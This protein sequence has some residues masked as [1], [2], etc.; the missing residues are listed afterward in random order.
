MTKKIEI[1]FISGLNYPLRKR[2]P[3]VCRTPS[4]TEQDAGYS[5]KEIMEKYARG[6]M[7]VKSIQGQYVDEEPDFDDIDREKFLS[8]DLVERQELV[9]SVK[10]KVDSLTKDLEEKSKPKKVSAEPNDDVPKDVVKETP[11]NVSRSAS[12]P[13]GEGSKRSESDDNRRV[14]G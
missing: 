4:V 8:L 6:L 14:G 7:P 2:K 10:Q 12:S 1:A 5:V 11:K 9:E 13:E 3:E